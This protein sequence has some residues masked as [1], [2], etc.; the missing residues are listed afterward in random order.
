M[1]NFFDF[2]SSNRSLCFRSF[3]RV[4]LTIF[5]MYIL[6]I[7]FLYLGIIKIVKDYFLVF[8]GME[9]SKFKIVENNLFMKLY[10]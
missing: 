2:F 5:F 3:F 4:S 10:K 8:M 7:I 9:N 1:D 6:E